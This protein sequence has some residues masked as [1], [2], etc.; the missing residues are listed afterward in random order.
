MT[1]LRRTWNN[2]CEDLVQIMITLAI[3]APLLPT[4]HFLYNPWHPMYLTYHLIA[5]D[6]QTRTSEITKIT[7]SSII[8][9][10]GI[11]TTAV[12]LGTFGAFQ[13]LFIWTITSTILFITVNV[14]IS[15]FVFKSAIGEMT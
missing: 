2:G 5:P 6:Q 11:V 15:A 7:L 9:K 12:S 3:S 8:N 13:I 14:T 4:I 10:H 1:R